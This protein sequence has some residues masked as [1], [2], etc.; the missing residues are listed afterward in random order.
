[1]DCHDLEEAIFCLKFA[2]DVVVKKKDEV[3]LFINMGDATFIF[4]VVVC[5]LLV[6][7]AVINVKPVCQVGG[8][9]NHVAPKSYLG[10]CGA[11]G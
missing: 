11:E 10:W 9:N 2:L 5:E 1:M 8:C 6:V 4:P 3:V 7:A